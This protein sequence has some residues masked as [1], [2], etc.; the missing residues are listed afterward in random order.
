MSEEKGLLSKQLEEVV[1][2]GLDRLINPKNAIVEGASDLAIQ[3]LVPVLD[4]NVADEIVDTVKIPLREAGDLALQGKYNEA[5]Q[6]ATDA[7]N[8]IIDIKNVDET[9]E[10]RIARKIADLFVDLIA[11]EMKRRS[12]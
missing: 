9:D 10:Q 2:E 12:A 7:L 3:V 6:R 8:Y 1:V 11:V 4:N 5:A